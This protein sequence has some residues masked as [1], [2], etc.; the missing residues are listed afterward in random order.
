MCSSENVTN[1]NVL[2]TRVSRLRLNEVMDKIK[3]ATTN[4]SQ[5]IFDYANIHALN[6]AY[7]IAWLKDFYNCCDTVFCDGVGVQWAAALL[8]SP[9]PERF[10]PPDW[11]DRLAAQC[12]KNNRSLFFIGGKEGAAEKAAENLISHHPGLR[13]VGT[14]HG[15]FD[16]S[17]QSKGNLEVRRLINQASPDVLI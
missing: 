17:P 11:I 1:V 7:E 12:V 13:V 9:V 15:Y 3:R 14:Y 10:T 16:K 5:A 8:G 2:G 6:T 4:G